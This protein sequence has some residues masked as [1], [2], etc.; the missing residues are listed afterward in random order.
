MS[1]LLGP[2]IAW[3]FYTY[4]ATLF[5]IPRMRQEYNVFEWG[6]GGSTAFYARWCGHVHAVEHDFHWFDQ[7]RNETDLDVVNIKPQS[8]EG[9]EEY[10]IS[11][12]SPESYASWIKG[13][14]YWFENYVRHIDEVGGS[15]DVIAIDGHARPACIRHALPHLKPG[16][17]LVL[18]NSELE[19][20]RRGIA[21][22]PEDWERHDFHGPGRATSYRPATNP[23]MSKVWRTT[24][25]R[26]PA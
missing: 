2:D 23:E 11:K 20:Y 13:E 18:D 8:V 3:P 22:I 5:L 19:W 9:I 12:T 7:V 1:E 26:K 10:K 25:W 6:C 4:E 15:F 17:Y 21:L 16:G 14:R 24:I